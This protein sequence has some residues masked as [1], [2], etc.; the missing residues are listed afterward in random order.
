MGLGPL[1]AGREEE[2]DKGIWQWGDG[3]WA[4]DRHRSTAAGNGW[5]W[6]ARG[7]SDWPLVPLSEL[8]SWAG[9]IFFLAGLTLFWPPILLLL[10]LLAGI[11]LG[12]LNHT[13][14]VDS[15][16]LIFS[17]TSSIKISGYWIL[18]NSASSTSGCSLVNVVL[19]AVSEGGQVA[20][21][22]Q[23]V[24]ARSGQTQPI[25]CIR[26]LLKIRHHAKVVWR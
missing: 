23:Q 4:P 1:H 12:F 5:D 14:T 3:S 26:Q 10:L 24:H 7:E 16:K 2:L 20:P 17:A 21:P 15:G 22:V 18:A 8:T 9:D 11:A 19:S 13:C 6:G 25:E